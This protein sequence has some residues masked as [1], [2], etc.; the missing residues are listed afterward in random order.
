MSHLSFLILFLFSSSVVTAQVKWDGGGGNNQWADPLNWTGNNTPVATDEVILDNSVITGNYIVELPPT[1]VTVKSITIS[2]ASEKNIELQLPS[3]NTNVPG[4]TITGP[5]YGLIIYSGGV[6]KNSSGASS[7]T[8]L[9][10]SDSIRI[11]NGG[12]LIHN[13]AR[14]HATNVDRLSAAPG[15]EKG[16]VELDI[17]DP[18]TTISLS[19]RTYGT[20]LLK[21]VAA[22]GTLN[23]TAAGTNRV[24]IRGDLEIGAGVNINLNFSDTI[25]IEGNLIQHASVFNLGNTARNV[26]LALTGNISQAAGGTITE[27]GT[28]QQQLLLSG[29]AEQKIDIQGQIL[30][31]VA[32]I[33]NGNAHARLISPLSLPFKLGLVKGNIISSNAALL[34]L[35]NNCIVEADSLSDNSFI[36]GPLKKEGLN[37]GNFLFPVGK[38]NSMRWLAL[39]LATGNFIVEYVK[40]NPALIDNNIGSGLHHISQLEYW[41]ISADNNASATVKLSFNSPHSGGVTNLDHLRVSRL[42][43]GIWTDAGN[44]DFRGAAGSNGW[45]SSFAAGGFSAEGNLF[46]LASTNGQENPLPI[47]ERP[48]LTPQRITKN[49]VLPMNTV[50]VTNFL[51]IR[52][53]VMEN[54]QMKFTIFNVHGNAIK[55]FTLDV[56]KGTS[57]LKIAVNGLRPGIYFL[58]LVE[59]YK[60][61]NTWKFIKR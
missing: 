31:D 35:S 45:V 50:S 47:S 37:N 7:G 41:N 18:S 56:M 25:F 51:S 61:T 30:N 46:A 48:R 32:F 13:T 43:A 24:K 9:S 34:T 2:P 12:R 14:G 3:T 29:R 57:S 60:E 27:T 54:K 58:S 42:Q 26:V 36:D 4:L 19:G 55:K 53:S 1:A 21:A 22:G 20:L 17:P 10:V 44:T 52:V 40:A 15:T 11:N 6:F 33:K 49:Q 8:P 39:N 28:G 5:G 16:I 23:Y 38:S 59:G